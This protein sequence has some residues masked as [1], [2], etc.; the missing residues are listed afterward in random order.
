MS[1]TD[2]GKVLPLT[3]AYDAKAGALLSG[4]T[5]KPLSVDEMTAMAKKLRR[6]IVTM[7][8]RVGSGHPG[9]SL[10]SVEIVTP[11]Y[12]KLINSSFFLLPHRLFRLIPQ[13]ILLIQR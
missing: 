7:I 5:P 2:S 6:H 9:G 10:S 3:S 13:D 4:T 11:L 8:G 1:V 12:F